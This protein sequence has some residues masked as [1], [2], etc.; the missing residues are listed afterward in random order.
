MHQDLKIALAQR[1][2]LP[3]LT[4]ELPSFVTRKAQQTS[5]YK[6]YPAIDFNVH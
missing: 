2:G 4:A 1:L 6:I 5:E 3:Y